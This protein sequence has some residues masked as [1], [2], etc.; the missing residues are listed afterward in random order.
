[1]DVLLIL[2]Q[3]NFPEWNFQNC[4][5]QKVV[6]ANSSKARKKKL[7]KKHLEK[8]SIFIF[9]IKFCRNWYSSY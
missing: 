6:V 8:L 4:Q 9:S 2:N 5:A 7:K 1:M 3:V